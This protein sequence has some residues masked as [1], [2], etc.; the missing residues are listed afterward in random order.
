[1]LK[2]L[3]GR[4][5]REA[6][7]VLGPSEVRS[8]LC[9]SGGMDSV[10]LLKLYEQLWQERRFEKEPAVFHLDHKVR[11]DSAEDA[12]FCAARARACGFSFYLETLSAEVFARRTS[13]SLE[14]AGRSLRYRAMARLMRSLQEPVVFV[15][16]HHADDY[17]ES[18]L[19]HLSR[20]GGPGAL[21]TLPLLS[22]VHGVP[23]FRP[24]VLFSRAEIASGIGNIAYRE[25]S[26]NSDPS[27][28]RNRIRAQIVPLLKEEGLDPV[29]LWRNFHEI[30]PSRTAADV[31]AVLRLDR[32][33]FLG[34]ARALKTA[35]DAA[36][37]RM[38]LAPPGESV[39]AELLRQSSRRS[40]RIRFESN[41]MRLWAD[42]RSDVCLFR[43]DSEFF[44][45]PAVEKAGAEWT[46]VHGSR[47][48]T[49]RLQEGW[50]IILPEPG[51][52]LPHESGR[53]KLAK[54]FQEQSIPSFVRPFL[55]VAVDTEGLVRI[56]FFSFWQGRDRRFEIE[57]GAKERLTD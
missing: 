3:A 55:P 50:K 56:V 29:R 21:S 30:L 54:L 25:D 47:R 42:E 19:L 26:T 37:M 40:F 43:A 10:F 6:F 22:E 9:V 17:L 48:V 24:L 13:Q 49:C 5:Y 33:M 32:Q 38:R 31:P 45:R 16:A 7:R 12:S 28:K 14:E 34:S 39:V 20:G 4:V 18:V 36:C 51:L 41:E 23:V 27:Y 2:E 57:R 44:K 35:L 53:K 8:V 15:T 52:R 1:M 11:S 46:I